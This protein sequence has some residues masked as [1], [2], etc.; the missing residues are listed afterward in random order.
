MR[1]SIVEM[2]QW[3]RALLRTGGEK[4]HLLGTCR[5]RWAVRI[6]EEHGMMSL[7]WSALPCYS[8]STY[9]SEPSLGEEHLF[10]A[11]HARFEAA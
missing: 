9:R 4:S 6:V 5:L 7:S 1:D 3:P 10:R 2:Q 8:V 11:P